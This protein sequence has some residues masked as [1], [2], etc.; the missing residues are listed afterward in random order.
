[1]NVT[2]N[3]EEETFWIFTSFIH[4]ADPGEAVLQQFNWAVL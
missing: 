3:P 4:S 1:M 2:E